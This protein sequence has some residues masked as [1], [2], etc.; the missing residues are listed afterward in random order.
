MLDLIWRSDQVFD[1][2]LS[3]LIEGKP[4]I[5]VCL[6]IGM[7][8]DIAAGIVCRTR[9]GRVALNLIH[10]YDPGVLISCVLY[11]RDVLAEYVVDKNRVI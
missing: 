2:K 5:R 4:L 3:C 7:Y 10:S 6:L 9:T 1:T 8:V 11:D